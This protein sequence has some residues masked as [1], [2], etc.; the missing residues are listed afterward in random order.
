M[1]NKGKIIDAGFIAKNPLLFAIDSLQLF[2]LLFILNAYAIEPNTGLSQI[3]YFVGGAYLLV[4]LVNKEF[5]AWIFVFT[6]VA[7]VYYAFSWFA[8]TVF[9]VLFL[10]GFG[11]LT[12]NYNIYLKIIFFNDSYSPA[13]FY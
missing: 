10:T 11:I 3:G 9:L 5:I 4:H 1:T 7:L 6:A 8:G 13:N 2:L 12:L